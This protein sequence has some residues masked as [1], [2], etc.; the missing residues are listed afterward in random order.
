MSSSYAKIGSAGSSFLTSSS[1]SDPERAQ[2]LLGAAY[3]ATRPGGLIV[4][5]TPNPRD[6]MVLSNIFWLDPTHV[7]PY[8]RQLVEVMLEAAG[9]VVEASGLRPTSGGR[10]HLPMTIIKRIWFGSEYGRGEAW[11]QGRRFPDGR[12]AHVNRTRT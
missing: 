10:R 6:W 8:P 3:R 5:V 12:R 11:I 4:I 7:R 9:F 2:E 1:I